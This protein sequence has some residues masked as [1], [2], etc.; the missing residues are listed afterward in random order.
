MDDRYDL[1]HQYGIDDAVHDA[2]LA[3]ARRVQGEERRVELFAEAVRVGGERV[4]DKVER[5]CGNLLR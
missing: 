3:A 1:D 4:V 5:G 2:V